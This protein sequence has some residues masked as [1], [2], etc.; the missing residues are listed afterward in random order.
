M[1]TMLPPERLIGTFLNFAS[2]PRHNA[3]YKYYQDDPEAEDRSTAKAG[4]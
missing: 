2:Q 3:Y 1:V 4:D